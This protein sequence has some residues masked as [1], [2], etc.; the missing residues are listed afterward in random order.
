MANTPKP[1]PVVQIKDETMDKLNGAVAKYYALL[2][3]GKG[4]GKSKEGDLAAKE[5]ADV[6]ENGLQ[7]DEASETWRDKKDDENK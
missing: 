5:L 3:A 4:I 6:V 1:L 2:K 7:Y